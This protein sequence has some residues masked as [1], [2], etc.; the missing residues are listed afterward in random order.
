MLALRR[1]QLEQELGARMNQLQGIEAMEK[2]GAMPADDIT[3]KKIP[4][5]G[6]VAVSS[7]APGWGP[8]NIVPV[9][10]RLAGQLDGV[11]ALVDVTGPRFIFYEHE[12]GDDVITVNLALPVKEPPAELPPP[13]RYPILPEIEA[14]TTVRNGA[15]A[16]IFPMVYHDLAQWTDAHGYR[17]A[18]DSR[19]IWINEVDD[20]ADVDQKVFEIQLPFT[21]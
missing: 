8:A 4:A 5:L 9:V 3:V 17:T 12:E 2:E 11:R 21:R 15:A 10:N 14:V 1:A 6:V 16:T 18:G 13:A 19:E 20:I 7:L